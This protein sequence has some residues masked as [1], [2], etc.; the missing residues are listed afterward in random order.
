MTPSLEAG[1]LQAMQQS[2]DTDEEDNQA[3]EVDFF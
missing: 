1:S 2:T 3:F